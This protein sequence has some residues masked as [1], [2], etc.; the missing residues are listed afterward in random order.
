MGFLTGVRWKNVGFM[1]TGKAG[2]SW[3]KPRA[4][5]L[6]ILFELGH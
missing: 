3:L 2:S 1:Q 6:I 5:E 4:I